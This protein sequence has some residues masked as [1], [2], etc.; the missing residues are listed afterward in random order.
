MDVS[1]RSLGEPAPDRFRLV[2]GIAVHDR[3]GVEFRRGIGFDL[4]EEF[5]EL[6]RTMIRVKSAD[7]WAGGDVQRSEQGCRAMVGVV[8]RL[9]LNLAHRSIQS[10]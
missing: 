4:I 3:R 6:G 7:H 2:G 1:A 10:D 5:S 9:P 8:A